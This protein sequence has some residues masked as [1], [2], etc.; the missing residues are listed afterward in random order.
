MTTLAINGL[1]L[2]PTGLPHAHWKCIGSKCFPSFPIPPTH[3][4]VSPNSDDQIPRIK[5]VSDNS[6]P[7]WCHGKLEI[8]NVGISSGEK[9]QADFSRCWDGVN[10]DSE[11]HM[12][13]VAYPSSGT[14]E[15]N[16]PCPA[17][18]PVPIPQLFYEVVWDTTQFNDKS[19][20]PEDTTQQPFV[21]SQGD[22]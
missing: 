20:W 7:S 5:I 8:P 9:T 19:L 10:L 14:F 15:N 3:L 16:G 6:L 12:S 13:H 1:G 11:D 22:P 2:N 17:T 21:W 18:H 4:H